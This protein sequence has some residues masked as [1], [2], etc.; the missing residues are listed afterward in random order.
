MKQ[1]S[2]SCH[3]FDY[4]QEPVCRGRGVGQGT[5]IRPKRRW[6]CWNWSST[7][8]VCVCVLERERER[9]TMWVHF[10][11]IF[12]QGMLKGIHLL[13]LWLTVSRCCCCCCSRCCCCCRF[14]CY[15]CCCFRCSVYFFVLFLLLSL[16][17]CCC[18]Y[19][20]FNY[21]FNDSFADYPF[22][23]SLSH[24]FASLD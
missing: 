2:Q 23:L 22:A 7:A 1:E 6:C 17:C 9:R 12:G 10:G 5:V 14:C 19:C 3:R 15:C 24:R 21:R 20:C 11:A 18:C 16:G 4:L 8:S 13:S